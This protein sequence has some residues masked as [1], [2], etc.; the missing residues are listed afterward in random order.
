[1]GGTFLVIM[2]SVVQVNK[3][4]GRGGIVPISRLQQT[5]AG[6]SHSSHSVVLPIDPAA[7]RPTMRQIKMS[8]RTT[9][10]RE[11]DDRGRRATG[12]RLSV[13]ATRATRPLR[14]R[15]Q[16]GAPHADTGKPF[17]EPVCHTINSF[18]RLIPPP[19]R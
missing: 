12:R 6:T 7:V 3:N 17:R 2:A 19:F 16:A 8:R 5:G 11:N 4:A 18:C 10:R 13:R 9:P 15:H 1:M 14:Q